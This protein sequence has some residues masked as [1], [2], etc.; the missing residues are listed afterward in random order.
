MNSRV[1]SGTTKVKVD[2]DSEEASDVMAQLSMA[3][4]PTSARKHSVAH[5][6]MIA[7]LWYVLL[8]KMEESSRYREPLTDLQWQTICLGLQR[9]LQRLDQCQIRWLARQIFQGLHWLDP[10]MNA[11]CRATCP[12]CDDPCCDGREVFFNRADLLYLISLGDVRSPKG[13]TRT[14]PGAGCR[15]LG[16][17]GCLLARTQ[18]PYVCVWFLCEP[19]MELFNTTSGSFQRQLIN[20]L[21]NIRTCRLK[22][23]GLFEELYP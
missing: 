16:P 7:R 9:Q 20:V 4:S 11:Y 1:L 13:Q 22:L 18:R 19:Q 2:R 21:T 14:E 8:V 10:H 6:P 5:I 17:T 12:T 23:E 3:V 15:Y